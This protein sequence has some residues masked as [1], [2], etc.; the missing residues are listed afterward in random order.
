MLALLLA[1][2]ADEAVGG[3]VASGFGFLYCAC[4]AVGILVAIATIVFWIMML[5]DCVKRDES[6]FP[7]STG[8]TKTIWLV[9]LIASWF[10]GSL[11]WLAAIIYYFMV[12]RAAQK[13]T[14]PAA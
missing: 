7:N 6:E 11:Y 4:W 8:N 14:I 3:A 1:S 13:P 12:K 9:V 10:L 5:V 2:S